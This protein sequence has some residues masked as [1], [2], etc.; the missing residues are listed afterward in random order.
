MNSGTLKLIIA[1]L[2]I[3]GFY[4]WFGNSIPQTAWE[5]PKKKTFTPQMKPSELAVEG[6]DIFKSAGCG[7]CHS[8]TGEKLRGPDLSQVSTRMDSGVMAAFLYSGTAVMPPAVKPPANL[9][10]DEV[11][12]LV[13]YLQTLGGKASVKIGDIKPLK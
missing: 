1:A 13:A 4:T 11:T 7:V 10:D 12:A 3:T 5:A 2:L 8:V 9:N 6:K